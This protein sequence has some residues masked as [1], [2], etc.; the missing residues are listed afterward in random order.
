M[1]RLN[2]GRRDFIRIA[3]AGAA[4]ATLS[5]H[6]FP[7]PAAAAETST[8]DARYRFASTRLRVAGRNNN[9]MD[10]ASG[11][12]RISAGSP[13]YPVRN[14][15]VL[16][17]G[18][19]CRIDGGAPTEQIC[20]TRF[21]AAY[22]L[23][24]NGVRYR[25]T[26]DGEPWTERG[27][28][29]ASHGYD[30]PF[31]WGVWSDP[32][33]VEI[34]AN[35]NIFHCT[36][37]TVPGGATFPGM[38]S[39]RSSSPIGDRARISNNTSGLEQL[40]DSGDPFE[41]A[42][43]VRY[44]YRPMFMVAEGESRDPGVLIVGDSRSVGDGL[45]LDPRGASGA[46]ERGLDSTVGGRIVSGH[47]G[48]SGSRTSGTTIEPGM[49]HRV[50]PLLALADEYG[51]LPFTH[52]LDQHGNN[53]LEWN[54]LAAHVETLRQY[55]PDVTYVKVTI[56]PRVANSSDAYRTL[57]GQQPW[58]ADTYPDGD[59]AQ[60]NNDVLANRDGLFDAVFHAGAYGMA[61]DDTDFNR[62]RFPEF[63]DRRGVL[64]RDYDGTATTLYV[65]FEPL[66]GDILNF[67]PN[68]RNHFGDVAGAVPSG[69]PGEW[70]V[71]LDGS[72]WGGGGPYPA[73]TSF[74]CVP[75][76][77]GTH[78]SARM[79]LIE[80]AAYED[81][82]LTGIFGP[83]G[84]GGDEPP[85]EDTLAATADA[86]VRGGAYGDDNFGHS[87]SLAVKTDPNPDF[88]REALV[89]FDVSAVTGHVDSAFLAIEAQVSDSAGD[90]IDL[91]VY[92]VDSDWAEDTVTWN[93]R[94]ALGAHLATEH[95]DSVRSRHHIDLSD[96]VSAQRADGA[97]RL[98]FGIRQDPPT[99]RGLAVT[100][101][102]RASAAS[103]PQLVLTF[104][105]DDPD[106]GFEQL[107]ARVDGYA[108]EGQIDRSTHHRLSAH[109]DVAARMANAGLV[110]PADR[111]LARFIDVA[112]GIAND[113]VRVSLTSAADELRSRQ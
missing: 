31:D 47:I 60:F 17:P 4:A 76:R 73:G 18:F 2:I 90:E 7:T 57:D 99:G 58:A 14:P 13:P 48:V 82:K 107:A 19:S 78:E 100:I 15:R 26:F 9:Q 20:E 6:L 8:E 108:A 111:A 10:A 61:G 89:M 16:L 36:L 28:D 63:V 1:A 51:H 97:T 80:T 102:G 91:E 101:P 106:D 110:A 67:D 43:W 21:S 98:S 59:R 25:A 72:P 22:A 5:P 105:T 38:G 85:A 68:N 53:G 113:D 29:G 88:H 46:L 93:T 71:T 44:D 34:P 65:D 30:S 95:V 12:F 112:S 87:A 75:T 41:N 94:P 52:I 55:F 109:L 49:T 84:G 37:V 39:V 86:Y 23:E 81:M 32:I 66:A 103:G 69:S 33:P 83:I 79:H 24:V 50:A 56:P 70:Q 62:S 45:L 96:H 35:S 27:G 104:A 92:A 64:T 77:D 3:G 42:G 40:L 11:L 74:A 54:H